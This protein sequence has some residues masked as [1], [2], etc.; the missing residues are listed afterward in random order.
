MPWSTV[1]TM[2]QRLLFIRDY[3][4]GVF[5]FTELCARYSI[6]R[7]TGYA[8]LAR[9]RHEGRAGLAEHSRRPRSSPRQTP[10]ALI[11]QLVEV[12]RQH[13]DWGPKK[14]LFR[15]DNGPPFASYALARLS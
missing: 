3:E 11:D 6:S 15:S 8:T 7:E 10:A 2:T 12:R 9:Y 4:L 13:P 5:S 14:L 1:S